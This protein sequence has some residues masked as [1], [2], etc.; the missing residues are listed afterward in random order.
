LGTVP[1]PF[2]GTLLL[3]ALGSPDAAA[4]CRSLAQAALRRAAS[5][6][7]AHVRLRLE[8]SAALWRAC[9]DLIESLEAA[10]PNASA[11]AE[12]PGVEPFAGTG[13]LPARSRPG[14][15]RAQTAPRKRTGWTKG[16]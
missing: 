16:L 15:G 4:D 10:S 2:P 13:R 3:H 1:S 8:G 5:A 14:R 7:A 12:P 9:A 6:K 11:S